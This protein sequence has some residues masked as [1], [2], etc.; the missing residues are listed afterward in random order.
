[1]ENS[2]KVVTNFNE[3]IIRKQLWKHF[4]YLW[5]K[6]LPGL[7][8]NF[9]YILLFLFIFDSILS[10]KERVDF[11]KFSLILFG[12]YCIMYLI[13][14]YYNK[15]NFSIKVNKHIDEVKNYDPVTELYFD[16]NS[17]YIKNEQYDL[18]SIWKKTSYEVSDR[19][20]MIHID[21]GT[22][23]TFLISEEETNQFSDILEFLKNRSQLKK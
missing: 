9:F 8:K 7:L 1:M 2:L 5:K 15:A 14:F 6:K 11:L 4:Y 16:D 18:R 21:M 22:T 3:N 20:I 23:F 17:F 10:N 19:I 13:I 12:A